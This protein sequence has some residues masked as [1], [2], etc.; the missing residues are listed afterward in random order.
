[1][2]VRFVSP[3]LRALD[4]VRA[5][6]LLLAHFAEERPLLGVAG[7]V[8]FRLAGQ[9]SRLLVRGRTRGRAGDRVLLPAR[10]R[11]SQDRILM[12]GLGPREGFDG[13]RARAVVAEL[14]GVL[15]G[16]TARSVLFCLPGRS[17]GTLSP[18]AAIEAFLPE[19]DRPHEQDDVTLIEP[20]DTV[21]LMRPLIDRARR[22]A[23]AAE[24]V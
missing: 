14:F 6:V 12:A 5:E 3:D 20:A 16:L 8:D 18:E 11:L 22:R 17:D 1:M 10:P 19:L 2:D 24:G 7:L 21:R 23:R 13:T 4:E 15:D 9:L